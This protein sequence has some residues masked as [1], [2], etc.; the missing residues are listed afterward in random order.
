MSYALVVQITDGQCDLGGV[1]LHYVLGEPLSSLEY[2]VKLASTDKG[3]DEI[4]SEVRLEQ[5]VHANQERVVT[6]KEDIFL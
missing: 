3:H 6:R 4:E 1:E 2:L 5:V